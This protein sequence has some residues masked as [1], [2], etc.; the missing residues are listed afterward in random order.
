MKFKISIAEFDTPFSWFN[1]IEYLSVRFKYVSSFN[2]LLIASLNIF[3]FNLVESNLIPRPSSSATLK[4]F[5][6]WSASC[7]MHINGTPYNI[8]SPYWL[9]IL[10]LINE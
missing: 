9:I 5:R 8:D 2:T 10:I 7:G 3:L 4:A 6:G 1:N